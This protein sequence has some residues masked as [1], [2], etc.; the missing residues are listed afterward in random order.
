VTAG[1]RVPVPAE[2]GGEDRLAGSLTFRHAAYLAVAAAGA[3]VM[4]L[5]D[6]SAGRLVVGAALAVAGVAGA[7]CRPYGEPLDRL[8]PAAVGFL[9]RRRAERNAA[10]AITDDEPA[11]APVSAVAEP[12][13]PPEMTDAAPKLRRLPVRVL[14]LGVALCAVVTVAAARWPH[15]VPPPAPVPHVVV[16]PIPV[17]DPWEEATD[18]AV[19]AWID[20]VLGT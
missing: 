10:E 16:V 19:D 3:A 4:L 7:A 2:T 5:G 6:R 20:D 17:P 9:R 11:L 8:V 18:D 1:V 12:V 13:A 15:P 14:A